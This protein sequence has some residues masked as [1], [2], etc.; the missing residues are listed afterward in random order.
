MLNTKYVEVPNQQNGQP[1]LQVNPDA[2]GQAWFVKHIQYVKG[3]GAAMKAL[4]HFTPKDTAIVE[5]SFKKDIPFEPVADSAAA[6]RLVK[7]DNDEITYQSTSKT[8]Q[9][10]V[11]SEIFYD[12][13]WKAYIDDKEAPIVQTNYVLRGLAIP[14]GNHQVK[15]EFKPASYYNSNKAAV[16][17]SALIWLL[18]I[19]AIVSIV[20]KNK[21]VA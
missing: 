1:M 3:Q 11:F 12:R 14:A 4:D 10:A 9:F 19:G 2:L 18:L 16:G 5:E 17:A 20:R 7:N 6:V 15:F 21:E 8:N 13:G